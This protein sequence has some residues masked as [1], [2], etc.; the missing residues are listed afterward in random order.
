MSLLWSV[1]CQGKVF[2]LSTAQDQWTELD[3]NGLDVKKISVHEFFTWCI[4]GDHRIYIYVPAKDIPIR[5]RVVTYE[6]EV[7][8]SVITDFYLLFFVI[9]FWFID[10]NQLDYSHDFN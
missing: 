10:L 9:Q 5:Y 8:S 1:D 7:I 3:N 6:N 4:G 2:T